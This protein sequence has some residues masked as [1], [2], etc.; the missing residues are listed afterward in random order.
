MLLVAKGQLAASPRTFKVIFGEI[1]KQITNRDSK[2]VTKGSG[3]RSIHFVRKRPGQHQAWKPPQTRP[4]RSGR[5]QIVQGPDYDA[6]MVTVKMEVESHLDVRVAID[7]EHLGLQRWTSFCRY[8]P[9]EAA[10]SV[11]T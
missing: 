10:T 2:G 1:P 7:W 6:E 5:Q 3:P 4:A 8:L 9:V 11:H